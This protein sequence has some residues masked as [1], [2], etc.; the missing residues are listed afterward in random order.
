[1]NAPDLVAALRPVLTVLGDLGVRHF[2]GGSIASSAHGVARASLD[3]DV[4][5]ELEAVLGDAVFST[6]GRSLEAVVG[7]LLRSRALTLAVAESCSGGLL[8]SRMTDV[9]GS[10]GY[11]D[12]GAVCYS[13]RSKAAMLGISAELIAD[14]GGLAAGSVIELAVI[15]SLVT[16][17]IFGMYPASKAAKMDPVEALRYE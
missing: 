4:V 3:V 1:M 5:A 8:S 14:H 2:V 10:S 17:L 6:D 16:G 13:N 12:C 7:D 15:L 9:P 11:F